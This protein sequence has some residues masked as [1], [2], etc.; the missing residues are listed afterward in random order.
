[1]NALAILIQACRAASRF[2]RRMAGGR[3]YLV[4]SRF[5][6]RERWTRQEPDVHTMVMAREEYEPTPE[7]A[8]SRAGAE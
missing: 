3:W 1:M 7:P 8:Y 2:R 4:V 5:D 6:C